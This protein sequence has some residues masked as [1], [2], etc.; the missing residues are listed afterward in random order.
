MDDN[1]RALIVAIRA[2][3]LTGESGLLDYVRHY[4][5]FVERCQLPDGRFR[6]FMAADG[7]WLD[8]LGSEDSNGRA[9]WA[10]GFA[11]RHSAQ[12]EVRIRALRCLDRAM[13][14]LASP[15]PAAAGEGTWRSGGDR[16]R[17]EPGL[18]WLHA[19]AF[20]LLGLSPWRG[21][22]PSPTVDDLIERF[23]SA[24]AGAYQRCS[25]PAWRWFE[26][27]LTYCNARL[28]EALLDTSYAEIG[29][30]SLTWLCGV[31]EVDGAVSLI[32][33]R[34]WYP[35]GGER[36]V[37]DQQA[38]DASALVSACA[39]AYRLSGDERFRRWAELGYAWFQG[40]N[41]GRRMMID[42][43]TGGCYDGLEAGGVNLNQGAESLLAWL[44][45]W[46]D[47]AEQGWL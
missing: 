31:L 28:P 43:D 7:T 41:V 5:A 11:A 9:I 15:S 14:A 21:A 1:A 16:E 23:A 2:L 26:D 40:Q 46:E 45:A 24:L 36:A 6:N 47:M 10:L 20:A 37:Y 29:L 34:G 8:E 42:P 19:Q 44:L 33:N 38:V 22:E 32:G 18:S 17:P 4:L 39:A 3:A 27:E 25:A 13:V 35:R 12:A 30:E